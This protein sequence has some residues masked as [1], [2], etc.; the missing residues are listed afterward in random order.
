MTYLDRNQIRIRRKIFKII[1]VLLG[2]FI[3]LLFLEVGLRMFYPQTSSLL[4]KEDYIKPNERITLYNPH[5]KR[6]YA[7]TVI[8]NSES[9]RN[10]KEFTLEHNNPRIILLGDSMAFGQG[11][12]Q[13]ESFAAI[14]E[15]NF[16]DLEVLNLAVPGLSIPSYYSRL[17]TKGL[18]YNPDIVIVSIFLGNDLRSI[19]NI[20]EINYTKSYVS[21]NPISLFLARN[22]HSLKFIWRYIY[23]GKLTAP[24]VKFFNIKTESLETKRI[25]NSEEELEK[26][27]IV[28]ETDLKYYKELSEK[29]NFSLIVLIIPEREQVDKTKMDEYLSKINDTQ[30]DEAEIR[31]K[32]NNIL[33]KNKIIYLDTT[34]ELKRLNVNNTFYFE[35][36]GHLNKEGHRLIGSLLTQKLKE[37]NLL[38]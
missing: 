5:L 32:I 28:F 18:E 37:E 11:V 23:Q 13:N 14:I 8:T 9:M 21:P 22:V 26:N 35:I 12:E 34:P 6:E 2:L 15:S 10:E 29:N 31:K 36:D 4:S 33:E 1:A 24:I 38:K 25:V 17:N 16:K 3:F 19:G 30:V 20:T 27:L 7:Y